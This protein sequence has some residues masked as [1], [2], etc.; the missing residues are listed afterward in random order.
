MPET[1]NQAPD[2]V[3][4]PPPPVQQD[5]VQPPPVQQDPVQPPPV[6]QDPVQPPPVQQDPVQ[7]PPVQQDPVRQSV[8]LAD[9]EFVVRNA[10]ARRTSLLLTPVPEGAELPGYGFFWEQGFSAGDIFK[11]GSLNGSIFYF[12]RCKEGFNGDVTITLTVSGT[13]IEQSVTVT[14]S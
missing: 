4:T 6:Q 11:S 1:A 9:V 7:P 3:I 2:I 5:P 12:F 14:C 8:T 10:Q 13:P